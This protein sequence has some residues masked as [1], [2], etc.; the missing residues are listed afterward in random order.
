MKSK[1]IVF[2][3]VSVGM[4][5]LVPAFYAQELPNRIPQPAP[6]NTQEAQFSPPPL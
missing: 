1:A 6:Y 4:A 3:C 2:V 5:I